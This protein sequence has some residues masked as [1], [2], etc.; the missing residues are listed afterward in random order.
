MPAPQKLPEKTRARR[1]ELLD[2]LRRL[3]LAEGF[4]AFSVSDMAER[5]HCSKSTLYLVAPSKEQIV[6]AAVRSYFK[7]AAERIEARV[8]ESQDP[9]RLAVYLEAVA[10]ELEPA[11]EQFYADL[12][13]FAP[14]NEVYQENTLVAARRVRELVAEGVAAGVLRP[15]DAA[16]VGSAVA[17]VMTGIQNGTIKAATGLDD[18]EAYRHLADL[19]MASLTREP[20]GSHA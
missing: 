18:A 19:V 1:E 17:Q 2:G 9:R 10:S 20:T 12:A 4:S 8:A 16:F 13:A 14:A 11:S 7:R 3:F 15:V 5:L 6:V